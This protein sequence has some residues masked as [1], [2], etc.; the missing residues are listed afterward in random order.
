MFTRIA[1]V[2]A[3]GGV[4]STAASQDRMPPIPADH[5]TDAQTRA[6][7]VFIDARKTGLS[8][9]SWPRLRSPDVMSRARAVGGSLRVASVRPPRLSE[10][11]ILI[12]ASRWTQNLEW[13]VNTARTPVPGG[14]TP[15][16]HS[17]PH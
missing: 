8:G 13:D 15:A 6:I 7:Q 11:A 17:F 2:V 14:H 4:A 10:F 12:T 16:L 1:I 3:I 5:I 9:P